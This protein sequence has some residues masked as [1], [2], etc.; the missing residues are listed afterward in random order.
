MNWRVTRCASCGVQA[1]CLGSPARCV[2]HLHAREEALGDYPAEVRR[3]AVAALR[4]GR[5]GPEV[6]LD[7]RVGCQTVWRWGRI[8]RDQEEE[9]S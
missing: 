8:A 5:T 2:A 4:A 3:A 6:A 1:P 9:A 7:L